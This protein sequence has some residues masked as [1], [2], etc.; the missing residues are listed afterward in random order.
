M[1]KS[2]LQSLQSD[3]TSGTKLPVARDSKSES[4]PRAAHGAHWRAARSLPLH[5]VM[6]SLDGCR[7]DQEPISGNAHQTQLT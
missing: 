4:L 3:N 1:E 2:Q 6:L 5:S 7:A